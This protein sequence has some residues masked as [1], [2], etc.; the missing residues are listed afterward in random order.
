M[1]V[2]ELDEEDLV[3]CIFVC[4]GKYEYGMIFCDNFMCIEKEG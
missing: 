2:L 3:F 1:G 4:F